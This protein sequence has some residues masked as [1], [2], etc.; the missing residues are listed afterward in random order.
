MEVELPVLN[1]LSDVHDVKLK[2]ENK[3]DHLIYRLA[4]VLKK[5]HLNLRSKSSNNEKINSF[6]AAP[7]L[8]YGLSI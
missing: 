3:D 4:Q 5:S 6:L 8:N 2:K 7:H 1:N